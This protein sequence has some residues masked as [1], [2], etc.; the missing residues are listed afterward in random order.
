MSFGRRGPPRSSGPSYR[1]SDFPCK[2]QWSGALSA[3]WRAGRPAS[4]PRGGQLGQWSATGHPSAAGLRSH[5]HARRPD[6]IVFHR[7][8]RSPF[9]SITLA[10]C[11]GRANIAR[12]KWSAAR[13]LNGHL[14]W[15][16]VEDAQLEV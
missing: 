5:L 1:L 6:N 16:K 3:D 4:R 2:R 13:N 8:A 12:P 15:P 7:K 14:M 10:S 11:S 9:K